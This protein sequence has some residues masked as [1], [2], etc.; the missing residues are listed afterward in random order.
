[1][2]LHLIITVSFFVAACY[3]NL[4]AD[5]K[6]DHVDPIVEVQPEPEVEPVKT[7]IIEMQL[8]DWCGPCR[9]FKAS[10]AIKELKA[11]GWE[12][13]YTDGIAKS[14]PSFRVWVD[15]KSAVFSGYSSKTSFFRTLKKHIK[16]LKND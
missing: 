9:R 2:K 7:A 4:P 13:K 12:I 6:P 14:Y 16:D 1:M 8:A 15:G 10:G 11:Q 3:L 5:T